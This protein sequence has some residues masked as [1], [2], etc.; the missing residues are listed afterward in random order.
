MKVSFENPDKLNGKLR[1]TVEE[2]DFKDAVEKELKDLRKRANVNGFR[3]GQAPMGLIRR[4][5]G[6]SAKM[7]AV[8]NVVS[9]TL[10]KYITDN[11]IN[12]IGQPLAAD[13]QQPVE[14]ENE[15]PYEFSFDIA[16][17]PELNFTLDENDSLEYAEVKIDDE[18]IDKQVEMFARNNGKRS[19][20]I[21]EYDPTTN[22]I[23]YGKLKETGSEFVVENAMIMPQYIKN[24]DQKKL[25]E[26]SKVGDTVTFNP[27]TAY[28]ESKAEVKNLL[29]LSDEAELEQHQGDFEFTLESIAR[30]VPAEVNEELFK[31]VYGDEEVKTEEDFRNKIREGLTAQLQKDQDLLFFT[32]IRNYVSGKQGELTFP[33]A[34]IKKLMRA[35]MEENKEFKGNVDE[36]VE[37][38]FA[39]NVKQLADSLILAR[40]NELFE[41]KLEYADIEEVAKDTAKMQFAQYGMHSVPD[42]MMQKYLNDMLARADYRQYVQQRANELKLAQVIKDKVKLTKKEMTLDEFNEFASKQYEA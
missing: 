21:K 40:L 30:M 33:D 3:R 26:G 2:A 13:D 23:V 8:N 1:L 29:R 36:E 10:N 32:T 16:V 39:A 12:M 34:L 14:L 17:A 7:N 6:L 27:A 24:E 41:V 25:F 15:A 35:S 11:K 9:E 4:Q 22:D 5:Y 18:L 37:K 19:N 42:D 20:D 28:A 38:H 31:A